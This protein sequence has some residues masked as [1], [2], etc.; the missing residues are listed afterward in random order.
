MPAD[1][2]LRFIAPMPI[3]RG[4]GASWMGELR[5]LE[6]LGFDSAAISHHVTGGWQL[7]PIPA[8]AFAAACT[9]R[10]RVLSL[11]VQSPLQHPALLAKDI[12][13]I[14]RLSG[15]RVELGI[16]AGWLTEDYAALGLTLDAGPVRVAQ[17]AEALQIIRSFF[18]QSCVDFRGE[19]YQISGLEGLPTCVQRPGPPVLVGAAGP[20]MLDLA[21]Q[22]ADIVGIQPRMARGRIDGGAVADLAAT[23]LRA[24]V[25]RVR[26]AAERAGRDTPRLQFSVPYLKVTDADTQTGGRSTWTDPVEAHMDTLGDSPA[27]LVGTA[28]ECAERLRDHSH[29]FGFDYWHL[30]QNT[31]AAA[32]VIAHLR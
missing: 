25:T 26:E 14:D 16:G 11:V 21:G 30:G 18:T 2:Q 29:R 4:D 24:K 5:R 9:T 12:A 28:A 17:F 20:R 1:G 19:H 3:L 8:M 15:G 22:H 10:L 7:G 13:T 23:A 32:R 6:D 27:V 31:E